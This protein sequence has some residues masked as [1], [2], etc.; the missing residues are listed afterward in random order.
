ML[1][2]LGVLVLVEVAVH[3]HLYQQEPDGGGGQLD[4]SSNQSDYT[5]NDEN[6]VPEPEQNKHLTRNVKI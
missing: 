2:M 4:P 6:G 1:D 5:S 3:L